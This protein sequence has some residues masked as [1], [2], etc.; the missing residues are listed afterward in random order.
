MKDK[1]KI[2]DQRI[3]EKKPL[4]KKAKK[5]HPAKAEQKS[6][7][8][9]NRTNKY[10]DIASVMLIV[11]DADQKVSLIN[12]KGCEILGYKK[13]EIIGK[14]W[15]DRFLP[16]R[17][18]K[19]VK[20][21]FEKLIP[22]KAIKQAEYFENPVLTKSGEERLIAWHNTILKDE[23]G[24]ITGTLSSGDDITDRRKAEEETLKAHREWENIFQAIGHPTII[25]DAK[26]NIISANHATLNAIG[27]QSFEDIAGKKCFEV[28]HNAGE[29][30]AGCPLVKMLESLELAAVEMEV[31]ALGGI[32][33]VSCTPV[34]D[35][36]GNLQK[37][38][39]IA[40]D[41]TERK[42]AEES[43]RKNE[44]RLQSIFR[45]SPVGIGLVSSPERMLL[46]ANDY[47]CKMLG[48]SAEE[49]IGKSAKDTLSIR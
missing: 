17:I 16:E 19:D 36:R 18:R 8:E 13:R 21:V 1:N 22:G 34:F 23:K 42:R 45:A 26:H 2:K 48:Y 9:R 40:T 44:E 4:Q 31:E 46:Q 47:L 49:L 20:T 14:N 11:I 30:P 5:L 6:I 29:P 3:K 41:I 27:V 24:K 32:F 35:D 37:I 39:H 28:F 15:F 43:L 7:Q 25:L 12:K 10:L 33:L 38:I